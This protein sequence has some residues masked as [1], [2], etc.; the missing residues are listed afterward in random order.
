MVGYELEQPIDITKPVTSIGKLA[1]RFA[2]GHWAVLS[3][4]PTLTQGHTGWNSSGVKTGITSRTG[5]PKLLKVVPS[6]NSL[7]QIELQSFSTNMLTKALNGIIGLWVYVEN[8][9]GYQVGGTLTG[10]ISISMSTNAS[11]YLNGV[12]AAFNT[13]QVR[14]GWNFLVFRMRNHSAYTSGSGI[15]EDHPYGVNAFANGT[16]ADGNIVSTDIAKLKIYWDNMSGSTMYFDSI[17]TGFSSKA[18]YVLGCDQGPLLEEV[19]IPIFESYGWVGYAAF[20]FNAVD[21]GTSNSTVQADMTSPGSSANAILSRLYAKGWDV[22]SHSVTHP[23]LGGMSDEGNIQYQAQMSQQWLLSNK[24]FRG[25]EFYASPQSSSSRLSELVIK[26]LGFKLQRH[27]R[28]TNIAIT[29]WGIDNPHHVGGIGWGS[30]AA[31]AYSSVTGGVTSSTLGQQTLA[32][33]KRT[34]DVMEVYGD[35][36]IVWWHGITTTG[37]TGSGEDLTGDNLL[38]TA[39]AITQA[40]AYL[41]QRELAGGLTVARGFTGMWYGT[42][43]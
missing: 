28:K 23:K 4:S 27:A 32:K 29:P 20:S 38:I 22:I 1:A 10:S 33:M 11:S 3:G 15:T 39:S 34:I 13:H 8:Q 18:Q 6:A 17:W 37:D 43:L 7:E 40:L 42:N 12:V 19:A 5:Q 36:C 24:F 21:T 30:N 2:T 35:T 25:N 31:I 26:T 14:E 41:R 9:P 16:G